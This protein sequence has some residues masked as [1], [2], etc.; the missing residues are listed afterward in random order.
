MRQVS[1][2]LIFT[3]LHFHPDGDICRICKPLPPRTVAVRYSAK[4]QW[5]VPTTGDSSKLSPLED[6]LDVTG[7]KPTLHLFHQLA[8]AVFLRHRKL[9]SSSSPFWFSRSWSWRQ[10]AEFRWSGETLMHD[11]VVGI[12][13]VLRPSAAV[14]TSTDR[15]TYTYEGIYARAGGL[16]WSI[17]YCLHFPLFSS[18][19][20][21][22]WS[23][24]DWYFTKYALLSFPFHI[25]I[26]FTPL[27]FLEGWANLRTSTIYKERDVLSRYNTYSSYKRTITF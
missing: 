23:Y 11:G 21:S 18:H 22:F 27:Q 17:E 9:L 13:T 10:A 2:E 14:V 7:R 24:T 15:T 4:C 25:T 1:I 16:K 5:L 26:Q 19:F 20:E 12:G 3:S 6:V 8:L